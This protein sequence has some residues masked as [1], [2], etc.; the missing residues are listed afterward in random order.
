MDT[1][2]ITKYIEMA[3]RRKYWIII[4][5]L[6]SVLGGLGYFLKAPKVYEA[7]T[8]ILVQPQEVPRDY[9]RSI[10]STSVENRL[11]TITQQVTSRTNLEKIIQRYN[12]L[13][14]RT[15]S[16]RIDNMVSSLRRRISIDVSGGNRRQETS[17][18]TI[19]FRGKD[20]NSVMKVTNALASNFIAE[21][22]R[23]R[24]AQ[25][26]GTSIFLADELESARRRLLENEKELKDYKERY[27]GGLPEQL[28]TNLSILT[29]LQGQVEQI[30]SNLRD[31]EN[32]KIVFQTRIAEQSR[33]R[34]GF[35]A[36]LGGQSEETRDI[37]SLR[38]ELASLEA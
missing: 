32:R 25:A 17:T 28:Q 15:V 12:L 38:N 22:L 33:T 26:Q 18:F 24:E 8:L 1:F 4:P 9:V 13:K 27:M 23:I 7:Q 5:F 30:N 34:V 19:A 11:R 35:A 20:P 37:Q 31:A 16:L 29:G 14:G 10:V 36:S 2:D 6:V 3:L 21:N